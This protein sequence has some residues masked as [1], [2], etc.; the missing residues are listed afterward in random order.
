MPETGEPRALFLVGFMGVGKSS[1]GRALA[2]LLGWEFIDLDE[3]IVAADGRSIERIFRESGES[4]FRA[5]ETDILSSLQD[6]PRIVVACGGG[7]YAREENRMLIGR[8][9]RAVWIQLPLETAL[10]RCAGSAGRPLL[11]SAA[12]AEDLYR[13]RLPHYR[14]APYQVDAEGLGPEEV[15]ECIAR[16]LA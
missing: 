1:T 12:Q 11:K 13:R 15:A 7:T 14:S 5:L 3:R 2:R 16:M 8:M 4:C 6:R 9:G 10:Q